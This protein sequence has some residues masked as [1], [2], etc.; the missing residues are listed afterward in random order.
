MIIAIPELTTGAGKLEETAFPI[1]ADT[2]HTAEQSSRAAEDSRDH[3]SLGLEWGTVVWIVLLHIGAVASLFCFTWAG[4]LTAVVLFWFTGS[5]G[6]CMGYHR[7]FAHR[8]FK[9][10]SIV[11]WF[12]AIVGTLGGEGSPLFWVASHRKH[13]QFSDEEG[14]PHSPKDGLWWSHVLWLFPRSDPHPEK[15]FQRYAKDLLQE[16]FHRFLHATF[17]CWHFALGAALLS[18]GWTAWDLRTGV[19]LVLFGIFLRLT[20]VLHVTWLVNS[21]SH[22]WGYR[23]YETRDNSR[24]LWWVGL[25]AFG[26]GWHNNHHAFPGRARHG[27]RWWEFDLTYRSICLLEWLGL[28]WHVNHGRARS[29]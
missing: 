19:S 20:C 29:A 3:G 17:I 10:Y 7:L 26:E 5:I 11:R 13:H 8:S 1:A 16:P 18:V 22:I 24:N 14:D 9:T 23:N 6:I 28:A 12:L 2:R 21:A 25:L 4:A 27:H 15:T